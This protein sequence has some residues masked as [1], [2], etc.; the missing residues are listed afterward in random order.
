[1][2]YIKY[3]LISDVLY[4]IPFFPLSG[5]KAPPVGKEIAGAPHLPGGYKAPPAATYHQ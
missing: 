1:M 5:H 3:L 2:C 4:K